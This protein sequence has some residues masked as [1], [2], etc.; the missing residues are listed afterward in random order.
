MVG[1]KKHERE[2]QQKC[3]I[4]FSTSGQWCCFLP[5]DH[6]Q[7]HKL[8]IGRIFSSQF[9]SRLKERIE[10]IKKRPST[11]EPIIWTII[12]EAL[13]WLDQD[14]NISPKDIKIS[15]NRTCIILTGHWT[16][17]AM[18]KKWSEQQLNKD[19]KSYNISRKECF[20][21]LSRNIYW[22]SSQMMWLWW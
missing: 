17:W 6:L 13:G 11:K 12:F 21:Q 7:R 4:I 15:D 20:E 1:G 22:E 14:I 19:H 2:K 3:L 9:L 16:I 10:M 18:F 5:F 8:L